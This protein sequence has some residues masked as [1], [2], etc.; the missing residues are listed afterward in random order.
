MLSRNVRQSGKFRK[1]GRVYPK[2]FSSQ[3]IRLPTGN[4][5][6]VLSNPIVRTGL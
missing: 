3:T 2:G 1:S 4:A 5:K 6:D